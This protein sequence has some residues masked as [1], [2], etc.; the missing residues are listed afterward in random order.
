MNESLRYL[1]N[2]HFLNKVANSSS[3]YPG[4]LLGPHL[5]EQGLLI[6]VFNPQASA[7]QIVERKSGSAYNAVPITDNGLFGALLGSDTGIDYFLRITPYEGE[8]YDTEDCYRFPVQT[9]SDIAYLFGQGTDYELYNHLGAHPKTLSGIDGVLFTVWAPNAQRVS[10]VGDFNHWDGRMH[11]MNRVQDIGIFEL[12]IP[13]LTIGSIYKFEI[14]TRENLLA[15]KSDPFG[16]FQQYRPDTASIVADL[17]Q[18]QWND[19][20]W[21]DDR[22]KENTCQKPMAIYEVHIGSWRKGGISHDEFLNYRDIAPLLAEYVTEMGYTHIELM[23]ICEYP[24]DGSWGYQVTG[25]YAPTSRFG[26]PEDF[27]FFIDYMH[28]HNISVI[29]DWVPAHF[30]KDA[31]GLGR[32]DGTCLYEHPD[33]RRGEHAQWGTYIFNYGKN[34]V[35]N[36][37]I[38]SALFWL[39]KFHIDGLRVDA[40]ASMLYLDYGREYGNWLPN[41]HGGHENLEAIE[42][43]KHM[44]SIIS[45]RNPGTLVIA[46]ESTAWPKVT[47]P[48]EEGGLGFTYKWNMGWMN[49]FLSYMSTDPLFRSGRQ[50][51]LTFS[52]V[53]AYSEKFILV[54]SH[55][56]VVH[57]KCSMLNKM[58][59]DTEQKFSN[60]KTAYG[61]MFGHPGKKLLFMGQDFAQS[62]EWNDAKELDWELSYDKAHM[63]LKRFVQD[64]LHIYRAYPALYQHDDEEE[65][66]SWMSKDDSENSQVSFIRKAAEGEHSLLFVCN[67]TPVHREEFLVPVPCAGTYQNILCSDDAI[68]G[69]SGQFINTSFNAEDTPNAPT[70]YSIAMELPP[71][72]VTIFTYTH[73]EAE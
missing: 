9:H 39:E 18:Y 27:M 49:D 5:S 14:K 50:D 63:Q 37:L 7:V 20:Q 29:L 11:Q 41:I 40:V 45:T 23:G 56:E 65:G 16:N 69:G 4:G 52:M 35:K 13:Y 55:D 17:N 59:G 12:F 30:P 15:L 1:Y 53:Y 73:T 3:D 62:K 28:Q 25:Y 71:L 26:T 42:F 58:P 10:V 2:E 31:H 34:E 21:M 72:S 68:Y 48:A 22:K 64:L 66:F 36:F 19:G 46:E 44:N 60:L 8:I 43:F 24:F 6:S 70:S 54:L 32:F 47:A 51:Q 33:P 38:A 61:F 57:G 67:F